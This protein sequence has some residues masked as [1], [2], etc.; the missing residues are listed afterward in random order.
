M[1]ELF[2]VGYEEQFDEPEKG[3]PAEDTTMTSG[4]RNQIQLSGPRNPYTGAA[5]RAVQLRPVHSA[6]RADRARP[7]PQTARNTEH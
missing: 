3:G 6:L 2:G 4:V 5:A 7:S 1:T